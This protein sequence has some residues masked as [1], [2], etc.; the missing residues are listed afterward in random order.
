MSTENSKM[1]RNPASSCTVPRPVSSICPPARPV[2]R[3]VA[4]HA[5]PSSANVLPGVE[6]LTFGVTEMPCP[7]STSPVLPAAPAGPA[8]PAGPC[9]PCGIVKFSTAAEG[10]PELLTDA[11]VPAAPVDVVPTATVPAGPVAPVAPVG[12]AGPVEP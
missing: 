9:G 4:V 6:S 11:F 12:P 5:E 10:V 7:A 2:P 3:L 1:Y 8:G